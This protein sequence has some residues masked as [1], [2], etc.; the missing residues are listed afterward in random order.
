MQDN[1]YFLTR[2]QIQ[3]RNTMHSINRYYKYGKSV[4]KAGGHLYGHVGRMF[5]KGGS[6]RTPTKRTREDYEKNWELWKPFAPGTPQK[7]RE[8][9]NHWMT[10]NSKR[11]KIAEAIKNKDPVA[12]QRVDKDR[13]R[14]FRKVIY[15]RRKFMPRGIVT[16]QNDVKGLY[17]KRKRSKFRKRKTRRYRKF[18]NKVRNLM[19]SD[20]GEWNYNINYSY[21]QGSAL[22][23]Q[24]MWMHTL[25]G[26]NGLNTWDAGFD[27]ISVMFRS[28]LASQWLPNAATG[29]NTNVP[30]TNVAAR[31]KK[32]ILDYT[33]TNTSATVACELDLFEVYCVKDV[34]FDNWQSLHQKLLSDTITP[35]KPP[36]GADITALTVDTL[37]VS[38]FDIAG[39]GKYFKIAKQ[40][41]MYLK[42]LESVS[43]V[44]K[45]KIKKLI[46]HQEI[47]QNGDLCFAKA[48]VTMGLLFRVNGVGSAA[49][50][51]QAFANGLRINANAKYSWKI[52]QWNQNMD[53]RLFRV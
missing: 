47:T 19:Y 53:G 32:A 52:L 11:R 12:L 36:A 23:K 3:M 22:D 26:W 14:R 21:Q 9:P 39:H 8:Y 30:A 43:F 17:R 34:E 49:N 33:I 44:R 4:M 37:G 28:L 25:S 24:G 38:P 6:P 16:Q 35:Q 46:T 50:A 13:G 42:P 31:C 20:L 51:A 2:D 40:T 7:Y 1:P 48:G 10:P 29:A 41:R 18:K 27:E 15:K 45:N 5:S